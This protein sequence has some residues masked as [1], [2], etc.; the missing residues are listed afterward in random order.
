MQLQD[1]VIH[2]L[3][4]LTLRTATHHQRIVEELSVGNTW[5]TGTCT[6]I[7]HTGATE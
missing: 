5:E 3:C 6:Y 7:T 4:H 2:M 1:K